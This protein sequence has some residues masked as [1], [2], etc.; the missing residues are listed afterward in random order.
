MKQ[1]MFIEGM[2]CDHCV[3]HVKVPLTE[4]E[5]VRTAEVDLA[6]KTAVIDAES[7]I[8]DEDVKLAI[9][10]AGYEVL[11]IEII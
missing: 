11:S 9:E 4:L 8:W 3:G 5:G 6:S 10:D 7:D 1:K 2:S